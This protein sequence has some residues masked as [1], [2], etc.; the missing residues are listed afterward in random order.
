MKIQALVNPENRGKDGLA[1]IRI[2]TE[3]GL[4]HQL[5]LPFG[6]LHR[7]CG[8]P[9]P[10]ALDLVI[11]ASLC[12]TVDKTVPRSVAGDGWT[13]DLHVSLPVSAPKLWTSVGEDLSKTL[14]FLTGD[15]WH[16]YFHKSPTALF[17]PPKGNPLPLPVPLSS[18][19]ESGLPLLRTSR[20]G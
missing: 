15:E 18:R 2:R 3:E 12:Y 10:L 7:R 17:V 6:D 13:R 9:S 1:D 16:L 14:T 5:D 11:T 19:P 20:S 4:E 8:L